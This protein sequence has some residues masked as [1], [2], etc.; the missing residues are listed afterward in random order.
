MSQQ[1]RMEVVVPRFEEWMR[2]FPSPRILAEAT[3]ENVLSAWAGLG[4]YSR[5]RN[6][7][8]TAAVVASEGWP[9]TAKD[10]ARLPGV[11][12]YTAAAIASLCF[13]ENVAMVDGNAIRVLSRLGALDVDPRTGPGA[14]RMAEIA[15]SWIAGGEAGALNEAT[16]ELGAL[17]CTPRNPDCASC[18]LSGICLGASRGEPERFPAPRSRSEK[19]VVRRTAVVARED[20]GILL[21]RAGSGEL[22]SG[23]WILP[24]EGDHA[25]LTVSASPLGEVRH[26]ITHHDVR[27]T[28]VEGGWSGRNPPPGWL[29]CPVRDLSE[30]IVSSLPRKA[31]ALAGIRVQGP[32]AGRRG[33]ESP[34]S[35]LEAEP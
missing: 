13:G 31:L 2:S 25:D 35:G 14:R 4:Y 27:W 15:S 19:V 24:C 7:R 32:G 3:E 5:A 33:G 1:T 23:L 28:V 18:P 22:L 20:R 26:A 16:M 8:R 21:R 30:R 11:G 6:L 34:S 10:L 12:P 9:K 29:W 17:V